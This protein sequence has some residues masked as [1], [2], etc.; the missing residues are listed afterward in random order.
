[1]VADLRLPL[2]G[3]KA[4]TQGC[5]RCLGLLIPL[6]AWAVVT[7]LGQLTPDLDCRQGLSWAS[8]FCGVFFV[9][10]IASVAASAS[11]WARK[12]KTQQFVFEVSFL[13]A[14]LFV[15]AMSFQEAATMLLD[16]CQR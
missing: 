10:S 12:G 6:L 13:V 9:F 7:E 4:L 16:A 14:L 3:A 2:L 11:G 1:M 15:V 5:L 8:A